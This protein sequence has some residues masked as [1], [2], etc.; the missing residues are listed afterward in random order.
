MGNGYSPVVSFTPSLITTVPVTVSSGNGIIKGATNLTVSGDILYVADIGNVLI[1]SVDS[2]GVL[3]NITPVFTTPASLAVDSVGIIYAADISGSTYYFS[4]YF[5]WGSQSGYDPPYAPGSCTP[6]APCALLSVGMSEPTNMSIDGYDNLF[7]EEG[8]SGAAEMPVA[9][10]GGGSGNLDLWYL[11]DQFA[12]AS[13]TP[14]SF[15][16]DAGGN[17]YTNYTWGTSTCYLLQEPL[18]NAEYSP[19]AN[20]VAGGVKCGFAGDGGQARS[21]EISTSIGQIAFDVA[22]NLYFADSGNQRIRRIDAA[23]GI[24]RTI[25]G[26]GTAGYSG[27]NSP[28]TIATLRTPTGVG[29]DSQG[30]VYILSN[31]STT[32]SAQIVRKVGTT[33]GLI[34]P[35][36]TQATSSITLLMNVANTGNEPL[37]FVRESLTGTNHTDFSID[38]NVTNCNFAAGNS[39]AAGQNCQIGLIFT[40]SAVGSRTATLNLV[41]NTVNGV[42]KVSLRGPGVA[43]AR[44]SFTAPAS[45]QI[46]AGTAVSVSVKVSSTYSTPSGKVRFTI[47]GKA[48]GSATLSSGT[49]SV[50]I[51]SL[52]SGSH[53]LVAAYGGDKE[54]APA[55]ATR[56][57]TVK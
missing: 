3:N 15:A 29:V 36:T 52:T 40:P 49:A 22:G 21:A 19:I 27:D 47:D 8:T 53:Q 16:V 38:N 12:Y 41:D 1:R 43:P 42:N 30:Q 6:G 17:L 26:N 20:R 28:A 35:S 51:A 57:L 45:A 34:F 44:V 11:S 9:G 18:Y 5:P 4:T 55:Q 10:I 39:L 48:A 56:M 37:T 23:T 2:T 14:G 13:S 25:A 32:G 31:S 46:A 50:T 33:G 24:I 7:F 54:H